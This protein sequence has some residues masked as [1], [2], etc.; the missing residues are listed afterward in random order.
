MGFRLLRYSCSRI[1][2]SH[3]G[4]ID[5]VGGDVSRRCPRNAQSGRTTARSEQEAGGGQ[6]PR[7]RRGCARKALLTVRQVFDAD[8]RAG[9]VERWRSLV[10]KLLKQADDPAND[11]AMQYVLLTEAA[12]VAAEAG[13]L[14]TALGTA[15]KKASRFEDD[16]LRLKLD[17]L[18]VAS[19]ALASPED[20][21]ALVQKWTSLAGE[22]VSAEAFDVAEKA[23]AGAC[24]AAQ[25]TKNSELGLRTSQK[26]QHVKAAA[27]LFVAMMEGKAKLRSSPGD[28]EANSALGKYLCFVRGRWDD[29]LPHLA[30]SDNVD[31]KAV[32]EADRA[33][34]TAAKGQVEIADRWYQLGEHEKDCLGRASFRARARYWYNL[35]LPG[36][37]G[38]ERARVENRSAQIDGERDPILRESASGAKK[39]KAAPSRQG[40]KDS[41]PQSQWLG[42]TRF[43]L[44]VLRRGMGTFNAASP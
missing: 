27:K 30:M 37:A 16:P 40:Q 21:T 11:A 34:P 7:P 15:E 3:N 23:A 32:A 35:A 36:L 9:N 12:Q 26:R 33:A 8:Y 31:L 1:G 18:S 42:W 24:N 43:S 13:D 14:D 41:D 5:V 39:K 10:L 4:T 2:R 29:G 22:A 25:K 20:Q 28:P 38:M 6:A 17:I 19:R 44:P